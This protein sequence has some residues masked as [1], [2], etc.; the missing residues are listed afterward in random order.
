M[1]G[2]LRVR[3]RVNLFITT[4][5]FIPSVLPVS[6]KHSIHVYSCVCVCVCVCVCADL[7]L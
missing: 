5:P 6:R 1:D 3:E 7:Y 4:P 2:W